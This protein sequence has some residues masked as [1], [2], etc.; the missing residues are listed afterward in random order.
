MSIKLLLF[1]M[2]RTKGR[3]REIFDYPEILLVP[4][5][6]ICNNLIHTDAEIIENIT[7]TRFP[8]R[9]LVFFCSMA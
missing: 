4:F 5:I 2:I 9:N 8:N 7:Q 3:F 6:H 1:Q